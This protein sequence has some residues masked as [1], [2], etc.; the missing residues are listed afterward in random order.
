MRCG[1]RGRE[2]ERLRGDAGQVGGMEVL[3]FGFLVFISG[4][5][6][7]VNV[8][9]VIDAKFA[10]TSAS[11]EAVRAYVEADTE[12]DAHAA[13]LA[14]GEE[15]L[16]AFGRDGRRATIADPR[17]DGHFGR[18]TRVAITVVYEVPVIVIPWLGGFG[19]LD[20]VESTASEIIDPY[21]D[22]LA[23]SAAC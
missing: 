11:R 5:L 10:V 16:A 1:G 15:T 17:L 7:F 14:R 6:L 22:G 20:S 18:C 12:A 4:T 9:G 19:R 3:P 2:P 13:A 8:W 21:R 23:G